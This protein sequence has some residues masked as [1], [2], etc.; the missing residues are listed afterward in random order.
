MVIGLKK[1]PLILSLT[2]SFRDESLCTYARGREG[3]KRGDEEG[4]REEKGEMQKSI[5]R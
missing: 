4:A 2:D 5:M 3:R 1:S